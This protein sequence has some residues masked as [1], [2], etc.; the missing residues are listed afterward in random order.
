MR[1]AAAAGVNTRTPRSWNRRY[2]SRSPDRSGSISSTSSTVPISDWPSTQ[3]SSSATACAHRAFRRVAGMQIGLPR[4]LRRLGQE[5]QQHAAGAPAMLAAIAAAPF[6]ADREP[7]P[8]RDL[9]GAQEIFMRGVFQTAA[10]ERDQ[11]L[12]AAHVRALVDGHGEMALAEQRAGVL[13]LLQARGV[14][15]RIGAQPVGRLE[16]DDQERHR[17]VGPGLQDEAAV[18][19]QRRAE[20]RRQ[21]DGLA[22]QLADRRR[23]N[24]AWCRMSSSA[25]PSRVRRPRRSSASTSNGSTASSTGTAD[26]AR[27]GRLGRGFDVRGLGNHGA[28]SGVVRRE[29]KGVGVERNTTP[30]SR[31]TPGPITTGAAL[32]RHASTTVVKTAYD[33][34]VWVPAFAGTTI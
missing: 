18:E 14:E 20:Q 8:G 2:S 10:V 33:H 17:A 15:A 7:H 21:H 4:A 3:A 34:V 5:L 6:L 11:A 28:L 1:A 23:D 27:T 9:L 25:G 32:L 31:R 22:E 30:S 19:F 26:G 24:R 12:V 16:V 13:A 29:T